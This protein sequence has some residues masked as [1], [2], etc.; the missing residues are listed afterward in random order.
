MWQ[1]Q[2]KKEKVVSNKKIKI[3]ICY[4][5]KDKLYHNDIVIP[6]HC[7]RD[8]ALEKS[9]DGT[10]TKNDLSWLLENMIGDNTGDNISYLNKELNE[11]TAIY[12]AWKNYDKIGNP[13]YIGFMHYRRLF[14]FSKI[15]NGFCGWNKLSKL[16]ITQENLNNIL[17]KYDLIINKSTSLEKHGHCYSV[18]Q[19]FLNLSDENYP[20]LFNEYKESFFHKSMH[21]NS[22]FIMKKEDFFQMCE[23]FIPLIL[24][25]IEQDRAKNIDK[26]IKYVK[27]NY[28]GNKLTKRINEYKNNKNLPRLYGFS[29]E[30]TISLYLFYLAKKYKN[31]TL[32]SEMVKMET[33]DILFKRFIK[34][35][36]KS[37]FSVSNENNRKYKVLTIMGIKFKFKT[38]K[39]PQTLVAVERE[40]N[41][42]NGL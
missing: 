6:I 21:A 5:K 4:H 1:I 3:L 2:I 10:I 27:N 19:T 35:L 32:E 42:P 33:F 31:K 11:L 22:M 25:L 30:Y 24:S 26:F 13:D 18:F 20:I 36:L 29:S 28:S 40:S 34:K 16:K 41:K 15:V 14:D 39:Q 38:N 12:W 17:D 9:K 7:G 23:N 8:V 37:I